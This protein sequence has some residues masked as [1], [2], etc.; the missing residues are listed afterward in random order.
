[1]MVEATEYTDF[2]LITFDPDAHRYFINGQ[3][4]MGAT[5]KLK[6][7][8]K[9][10]DRQGNATRVANR[11]GRTVA[12][13]LAEW[14][15]KAE[16]SMAL[17]RAVHTHIE[18]TLK[19]SP[20]PSTDPFLSLNT[21]LPEI[22]IFNNFWQSLAPKVKIEQV[23]W[24]IGDQILGLA[25]TVD[26]L[27]YSPETGKYHIWDWKTGSFDTFNKWEN[28]LT[29]FAHLDACKLHIYSLQVSLYRLIIEANTNLEMGDSY[30]V[31]LSPAY[32]HQVHKAVDLRKELANWLLEE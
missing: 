8:Q 26:S 21:Q 5:R 3:E 14:D 30:I 20:P 32:G 31:H 4:L 25:G 23:E 13:V 17:G 27:F 15:A 24:I 6:A 1:M 12:E 10:F 19:G 2:S 29:P 7:L 28:L 22:D 9:P 18:N 16:R 11:E